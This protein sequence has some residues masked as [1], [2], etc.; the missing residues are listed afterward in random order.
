MLGRTAA[1]P[2]ARQQRIGQRAQQ[3]E[4]LQTV[5]AHL[6]Q[7]VTSRHAGHPLKGSY[8]DMLRLV[9]ALERVPAAYRAELGGWLV[10]RLQKS[11]DPAS[12]GQRPEKAGAWWVVGRLG[13]RVSLYGQ[14]QNVVS[15]EI[16]A[17]W[18]AALLALDWRRVDPAAFAAVQIA[19]LSG[20]R[21]RDLDPAWREHVL[22]RLGEIA[23]PPAW[24]RMLR[25]VVEFEAAD[26]RLSYGESLPSGLRLLG[27]VG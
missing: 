24:S 18:L 15:P 6:E 4:L 27:C 8:D 12:L 13:A 25:E 22:Q 14:A 16:A 10:E 9:A 1:A 26:Q 20:D 11:V 7:I 5:G 23:A 19:R 3:L 21:A 2:S 17:S